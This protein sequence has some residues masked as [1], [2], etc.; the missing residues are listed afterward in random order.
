MRHTTEPYPRSITTTPSRARHWRACAPGVLAALCL[1]G[2]ACLADDEARPLGE[3]EREQQESDA[4][5][6]AKVYVMLGDYNNHGN[7]LVEHPTRRINEFYASEDDGAQPGLTL[8]MYEGA[9]DPSVDYDE[10]APFLTTNVRVNDEHDWPMVVGTN[11]SIVR[12][13]LEAQQTGEFVFHWWSAASM[14]LD[15]VQVYRKDVDGTVAVQR[16]V[17]LVA[18]ERYLV[19]TVFLGD[20]SAGAWDQRIGPGTLETVVKDQGKFTH[21]VDENGQWKVRNDVW[22]RFAE[23]A[24]G[25][26]LMVGS[27]AHDHLIGPEL[28]FGQVVGDYHQQRVVLL[29]AGRFDSSL[30]WDLMPPGIERRTIDGTTYAGYG[31]SQASWPEGQE[32]TATT[33]EY[34]GHEYD[35][36]VDQL[37]GVLDDCPA[38]L[39]DFGSVDCEIGG[40]VY[41]QGYAD[42][43]NDDFTARYE[44]HL[45]AFIRAIRAELDAE[46]APFVVGANGFHPVT[47]NNRAI[48]S[49]QL[50]V[51]EE[52]GNY[53]ELGNVRSV[54]TTGYWRG[55]AESPADEPH[56]YNQNAETM[57]LIGDALGRA[58]IGLV[59]EEDATVGGSSSSE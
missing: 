55:A 26:P 15:G 45:A 6:R 28:Q 1:L 56:T 21:L 44:E 42:T 20:H 2:T 10:R 8:S 36:L 58:M 11:T 57:L 23:S 25:H 59:D 40:F 12:G 7:G 46:D 9:Y 38:Q 41:F 35:R 14:V 49:A 48:I 5:V 13:Y 18:G 16:R 47:G 29:E 30:G 53:P 37:H 50:A 17:Q 24:E 39:Q 32:P 19:E 4:A 27:G 34:A 33:H 54:E 43:T 31:D 22:Y 51:S 3:P 52:R